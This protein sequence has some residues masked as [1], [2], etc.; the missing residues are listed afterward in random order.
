MS[1][2]TNF[3][4][5]DANALRMTAKPG[6]DPWLSAHAIA[7]YE[8]CPRAGLLAYE[9]KRLDN[10]DEPPAFDILPK[11]ELDAIERALSDCGKEFLGWLGSL[12]ILVIMGP[13]AGTFQHLEMRLLVGVGIL[14]VISRILRV[15]RNG[16]I[17]LRRRQLA[18]TSRCQE[19]DPRCIEMQPVNWFG[20]LHLGFE[21]IRLMDAL[22]DPE[23]QIEGKPWRILRKGSLSIPVFR[24]R[25]PQSK[26]HHQQIV[27]IMA[28][29][30]LASF[31][32]QV[33]CPYGIILTGD[34]YS[35][36]AVP[37]QEQNWARL[38]KCL[39][40]LRQLALA[41]D[42]QSEGNVPFD[43]RGCSACPLGAP[44]LVSLGQSVQRFDA[45]VPVLTLRDSDGKLFHT[46]CGDRFQWK[47]PHDQS[48]HLRSGEGGIL[49]LLRRLAR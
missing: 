16:V 4:A 17:L 11:Y 48:R 25:S 38:H 36:F 40:A 30:R 3:S 34:D 20:M 43:E 19:P 49:G 32:F 12:L 14:F 21:S 10:E 13:I 39:I 7:E 27:K 26:P 33:E 35:G 31:C 28:Y 6:D 47:P 29:C 2:V 44:R 23:W 46:D 37:N 8:F 22:R 9:N 41:S 15:V 5:G 45:P 1:G 42:R 24:T 18:L